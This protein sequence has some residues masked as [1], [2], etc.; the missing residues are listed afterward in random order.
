MKRFD[1]NN[2]DSNSNI[3]VFQME[4]QK[5]ITN[6]KVVLKSSQVKKGLFNLASY[7]F[8]FLNAENQY[9]A[10]IEALNSLNENVDILN[11]VSD[12]HT[13]PGFLKN[14]KN[15]PEVLVISA[16]KADGKSLRFVKNKTLEICKLAVESDPYALRYVPASLQ[17]EDVCLSA[18]IKEHSTLYLVKRKA[19]INQHIMGMVQ[20]DDSKIVKAIKGLFGLSSTPKMVHSVVT[21]ASI[22]RQ[23]FLAK[24]LSV[25]P[26]A[27]KNMP[28]ASQDLQKIAVQHDVNA[29]RYINNPSKEVY[30]KALQSVNK[31][32]NLYV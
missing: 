25:E 30:L 3:T 9:S 12:F 5:Y 27:I 6:G 1:L 18:I 4:G 32:T 15:Q 14:V 28:F 13:V 11:D 19:V 17:T 26:M 8:K 21:E 31:T 7:D 10:I 29:L 16:L 20:K 2:E 24:I 22:N 23:N